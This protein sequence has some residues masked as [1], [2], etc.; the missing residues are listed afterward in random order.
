MPP[1][2]SAIGSG[3]KL[4][5]LPV[6]QICRCLTAAGIGLLAI[7]KAIEVDRETGFKLMSVPGR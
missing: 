4:D 7:L 5:V 2:A 6:S 1:F 3:A